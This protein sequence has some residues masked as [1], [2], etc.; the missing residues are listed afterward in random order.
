MDFFA[1]YLECKRFIVIK[2]EW[3]EDAIVG[4]SSRVFFSPNSIEIP[5]FNR[6]A[7]YYLNTEVD[8]CYNAF[9]FKA[10]SK[11]K[12]FWIKNKLW[13]IIF[14]FEKQFFQIQSKMQSA[15]S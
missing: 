6:K 12:T 14:K 5:V 13:E 10:F 4:K 11:Q 15:T 2:R 8:S 7:R 9:I 3:I 1:V